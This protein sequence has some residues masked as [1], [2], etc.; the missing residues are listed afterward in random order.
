MP[1]EQAQQSTAT[2]RRRPGGRSARVRADVL[3]AAID[4]LADAGYAAFGLDGVARRAGVHRATLYRR[5]RTREDLLFDA[6]AEH[7]LDAVPIPDTGSVRDDLL[8]YAAAIAKSTG[9]PTMQAVIRS[10]I[11]EAVRNQALADTARRYWKE[12]MKLASVIVTRAIDRGELPA[13]VDAGQVLE[14]V[15]G[16]LYLRRLVTGGTLGRQALANIV[17]FT[18]AAAQAG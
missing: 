11:A 16:P 2:V 13:S 8:R 12:R 4:E 3:Q 17:D 6:I 15:L 9:T 7:A 18:L 1:R 10:Y 5:W 14:H